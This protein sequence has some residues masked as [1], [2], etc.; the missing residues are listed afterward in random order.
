MIQPAYRSAFDFREGYA[1]VQ[2]G[3]VWQ[4]ID[5]RACPKMICAEASA[6]KSVRNGRARLLI[7]GEWVEREIDEN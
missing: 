5:R 6:I 7:D 2:L 1:A 4:Y 3:D